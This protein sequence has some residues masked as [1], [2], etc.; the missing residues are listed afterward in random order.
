MAVEELLVGLERNEG[1]IVLP[2][3]ARM[4]WRMGRWFPALVELVSRSALT[5]ERNALR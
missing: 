3:R 1:V 4:A 5:A 2:F